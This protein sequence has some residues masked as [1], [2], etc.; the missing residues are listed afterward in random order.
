M[1]HSILQH[2][3]D[4]NKGE[5]KL[6]MRLR[7]RLIVTS[8]LQVQYLQQNED[9]DNG[10]QAICTYGVAPAPFVS[11]PRA[12]RYGSRFTSKFVSLLD[13][14]EGINHDLS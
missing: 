12:I 10:I 9:F 6:I 7:N 13:S 3:L 14:V 2:K 1:Y 4:S 11:S 5:N 8:G